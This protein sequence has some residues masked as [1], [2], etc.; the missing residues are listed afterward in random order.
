MN[1]KKPQKDLTLE[2]VSYFDDF[3]KLSLNDKINIQKKCRDVCV[4]CGG[5]YRYYVYV[6]NEIICEFCNMVVNFNNVNNNMY[7][8]YST[9]NQVDI[10]RC[11]VDYILKH[12][13]I[14]LP[15][16]VD[17]NVM[18]VCISKYEL[19]NL[20]IKNSCDKFYNNIK[21]FMNCD[22]NANY[23]K[24]NVLDVNLFDDVDDEN[25]DGDK[26]VGIDEYVFTNDEINFI[27]NNL[28]IGKFEYDEVVKRE[29]VKFD[30]KILYE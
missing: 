8:C 12:H 28:N 6:D 24:N 19:S 5:E 7:V 17:E 1:W 27:K 16:D 18:A 26:L 2:C 14:P 22:F 20:L 3:K 30:F 23:I 11:T 4:Y 25:L 29:Y 21:L 10:I 9:K 13:K 15:V